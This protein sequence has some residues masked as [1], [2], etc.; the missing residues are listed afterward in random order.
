MDATLQVRGQLEILSGG[1]GRADGN[2]TY[3]PVAS[4]PDNIEYI[5]WDQNYSDWKDVGEHDQATTYYVYSDSNSNPARNSVSTKVRVR[6]TDKWDVDIDDSNVMTVTVQS[7]IES[8]TRYD[9]RGNPSGAGRSLYAFKPSEDSAGKQFWS[10]PNT[11]ISATVSLGS[12]P[13]QPVY[14][15]FVLAPGEVSGTTTITFRNAYQGRESLMFGRNIY[16]D[17]I[18]M[19]LRFK[20]GLPTDLP[21]PVFI[22]MTQTEDIC[23]NYVDADLEFEPINV[24][25]AA[26]HL[27]WRYEGQD[28]ADDRSIEINVYR[29]TP[30]HVPIGHLAPTNHTY[31]PVHV[32]WRAK[33]VPVNSKLKESDWAYGDFEVIYVPAPHMTVPDISDAECSAIQKGELLDRYKSEQCYSEGPGCADQD[34]L[35][36]E[37]LAQ[38]EIDNAECVAMNKKGGK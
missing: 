32:Y 6:V 38:R 10:A 31:D 17:A 8:A 5:E 2:N 25:G 22:G 12:T 29:D 30:I 24:N 33:Y 19:G 13:S 37:L 1:Y 23:E 26:I 4:C 20:N 11:S 15:T 36:K 28:W 7:W 9:R 21:I 3:Y 14:N 18:R 27:E 16:T 34:D 35:R